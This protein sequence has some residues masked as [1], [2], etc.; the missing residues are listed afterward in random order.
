MEVLLDKED[1]RNCT[2]RAGK[3]SRARL[4]KR[5]EASAALSSR[6]EG[7]GGSPRRDRETASERKEKR[8]GEQLMY[9]YTVNEK[10]G[11]GCIEADLCTQIRIFQHFFVS[12]KIFTVLHR[13]HLQ[14][15]F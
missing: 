9:V 5:S 4:R 2:R 13:S 14:K 3:L 1:L 7:S 12:Y 11:K 6:S 15:T 10:R 8:R